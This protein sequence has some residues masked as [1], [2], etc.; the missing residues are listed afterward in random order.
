VSLTCNKVMGF[1]LVCPIVST[2]LNRRRAILGRPG[3]AGEFCNSKFASSAG[4]LDLVDGRIEPPRS[5]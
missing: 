3:K 1:V 2:V 4:P 5:S